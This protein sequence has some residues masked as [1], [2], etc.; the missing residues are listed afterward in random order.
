MIYNVFSPLINTILRQLHIINGMEKAMQRNRG[1]TLRASGNSFTT[2]SP[3][4]E[5]FLQR[6]RLESWYDVYPFSSVL[7]MHQIADN[8]RR[9]QWYLERHNYHQIALE[10]QLEKE[11]LYVLDGKEIVLKPGE[12]F[13]TRPGDSVVMRNISTLASR[14]LQLLISG[15]NSR[16]MMD[17]L[18]I[19]H[20]MKISLSKDATDYFRK[21]MEDL[22]AL[23][24]DRNESEA[25]RNSL[26]CHELLL[27][28]ADGLSKNQHELKRIPY[29]VMTLMKELETVDEWRSS[30]KEL[31]QSHGLS[32]RSVFRLFKKYIGST[33][34]EYWRRKQM[35][36]AR[37]LLKNSTASIKE[38]AAQLGFQNAFYFSAVFVQENGISPS[39]FRNT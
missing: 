18:G 34:H 13:I 11:I 17:S 8:S 12:L 22:F 29:S 7:W 32:D 38:I 1:L 31:A 16:M 24:H 35:E 2:Y 15:G 39:D 20:S 33:P 19:P 6:N 26:M 4:Y 25:W 5:G 9:G 30:I 21:R 14:Q 27:F 28:I 3:G 37:Y 10:F 36:K 23:L